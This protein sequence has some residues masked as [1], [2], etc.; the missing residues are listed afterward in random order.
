MMNEQRILRLEEENETQNALIKTLQQQLRIYKLK[1]DDS[2]EKDI[3]NQISLL[4]TVCKSNCVQT[5]DVLTENRCTQV[6]NN[7]FQYWKS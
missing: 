2:T 7:R 3:Q 1:Y 4:D 6:R 5:D